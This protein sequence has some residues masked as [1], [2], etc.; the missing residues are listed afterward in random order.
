MEDEDKCLGTDCLAWGVLR[1][2]MLVTVKPAEPLNRRV[3]VSF[4]LMRIL[5][6]PSEASA[7]HFARRCAHAADSPAE[8]R[9]AVI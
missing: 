6:F 4:E 5:Q 2:H 8:W 9:H 7:S 1:D 3:K